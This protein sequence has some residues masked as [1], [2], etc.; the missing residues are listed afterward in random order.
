MNTGP[1]RGSDDRLLE[2]LRGHRDEEVGAGGDV[3]SEP[4]MLERAI[5]QVGPNRGDDP[6]R[7]IV[8][9]GGPDDDVEEG[10]PPGRG[11]ARPALLEL[12]DHEDQSSG[13]PGDVGDRGPGV[14]LGQCLGGDL[15]QGVMERPERIVARGE[16]DGGPTRAPQCRHEAGEHDRA[17]PRT[18]RTRDGDER[19]PAD[20]LH[21]VPDHGLPAEEFRGV[22]LGEGSET[23]VRVAAGDGG[24]F[25]GAG[26][27][28][29]LR[30]ATPARVG[31]QG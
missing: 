27:S 1:L 16:G 20:G 26:G 8:G 25:E 7:R 3:R 11:S 29:T 9:L 18:A 30:V 2:L 23:D 13:A 19:M 5:E 24:L 22:A 28:P 10:V 17:L 6:H 4:G 15:E 21:E 12:I 14:A 31:G